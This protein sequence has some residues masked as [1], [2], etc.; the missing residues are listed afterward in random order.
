MS[1][2]KL[3]CRLSMC[4]SAEVTAYLNRKKSQ[5]F[6]HAVDDRFFFPD[7]KKK[8]DIN[9]KA[10]L[11][12]THLLRWPELCSNAVRQNTQQLLKSIASKGNIIL[13]SCSTYC[14]AISFRGIFVF[15][16]YKMH[17]I[18]DSGAAACNTLNNQIICGLV[19][20]RT[21]SK[22]QAKESWKC[23]SMFCSGSM[24][25]TTTTTINL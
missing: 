4:S 22:L 6:I 16:K 2:A 20:K 1:N 11:Y 25:P 12:T 23:M 18:G 9:S 14:W 3:L 19:R 21:E 24:V 17:M 15:M 7:I 8:F 5:F 10:C 13:I